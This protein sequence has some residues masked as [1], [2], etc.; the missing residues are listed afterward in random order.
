M[1]VAIVLIN[2]IASDGR[3]EASGGLVGGECWWCLVKKWMDWRHDDIEVRHRD[4]SCSG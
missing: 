2:Q 4:E 1:P 3:V